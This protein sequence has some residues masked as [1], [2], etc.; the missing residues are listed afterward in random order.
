M[1]TNFA[2]YV[3]NVLTVCVRETKRKTKEEIHYY[4]KSGVAEWKAEL[5]QFPK[6]AVVIKIV[7]IRKLTPCMYD[8]RGLLCSA[9]IE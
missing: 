4:A 7:Q 5:H 2:I 3:N 1:Y 8:D 9:K 6:T